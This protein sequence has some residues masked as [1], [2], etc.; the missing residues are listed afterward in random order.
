MKYCPGCKTAKREEEFAKNRSRNDGLQNY[1][2]RC[3]SI[4]DASYYKNNAEEQKRRTKKEY[5]FSQLKVWEYLSTHS[6][7]DCGESNPIVLE[8][9]HRDTRKKVKHVSFLLSN[10]KSWPIIEREI[11]K[12]DVRCANCHRIKTAQQFHWYKFLRGHSSMVEQ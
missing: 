3:K 5:L 12:C 2:R 7:I 6:C 1:C 10:S 9:D 8:F 4:N 11:R